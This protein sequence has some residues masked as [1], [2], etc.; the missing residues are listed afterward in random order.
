[1]ISKFG[2]SCFAGFLGTI[3]VTCMVTFASPKLIG[4]PANIAA[5][6]ARMLGGSWLAGMGMHF[7]I[8]TVVLP[9]VYLVVINRR[10]PAGPAVRG[11]AW[12]LAL[13]TFS[14]SV[15]IPMTGGGL[16]SSALG[17]LPVA[18]DSLIG[19]LAYGLVLGVFASEPDERVFALRH[20]KAGQPLAKP[21]GKP[22][23]RLRRAA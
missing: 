3:V 20:E 1:M 10:L 14:Q 8:G 5:V 18:A 21:T 12:G 9:A 19:H 13:W 7:L 17:G 15:V 16:F 2:R 23:E 6:L 4:G 22:Q 11:V